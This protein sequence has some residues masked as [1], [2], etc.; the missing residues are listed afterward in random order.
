VEQAL[1]DDAV[2][3]GCFSIRFEGRGWQSWLVTRLYGL[4]ARAG[5]FYIVNQF[6]EIERAV[7]HGLHARRPATHPVRRMRR[8]VEPVGPA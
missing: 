7:L 6:P 5:L 8:S 4:F 2:V 3:G 1:D